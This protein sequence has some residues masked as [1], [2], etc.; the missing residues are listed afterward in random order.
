MA[1]LTKNDWLSALEKAALRAADA[2]IEYGKSIGEKHRP[3]QR[4]VFFD[5]YIGKLESEMPFEGITQKD[6]DRLDRFKSENMYK[7]LDRNFGGP[8]PKETEK[9][10][11]ASKFLPLLQGVA[12]QGEDWYSMG[13]TKL[14]GKAAELGYDPGAQE[15]FAEFLDK[16]GEYQRQHDLAQN[17]KELMYSPYFLPSMIA[18]PTAT[19][20]ILNAVATGE[21]GDKETITNLAAADALANGAMMMAPN[22]NFLKAQP[23]INAMLNAG[24]QAGI[25]GGRQAYAQNESKTGQEASMVPVEAAFAAGS[26][27]PALIKSAQM[28]ASR[29]TGPQAQAFSRGIM[30]STRAGNPAWQARTDTE[31]LVKSYNDFVKKG[32]LGANADGTSRRVLVDLG[33]GSRLK[34]INKVP[35][36]ADFWGIKPNADGTYS[37]SEIMKAY[38]KKPMQ[39]LDIGKRVTVPQNPSANVK[40]SEVL[41]TPENVGEYSRLFGAK[42]ADESSIRN[43]WSKYGMLTGRF[44]GDIGGSIEPA[45]KINPA[46]VLGPLMSGSPGDIPERMKPDHKDQNWYK[47]LKNSKNPRDVEAAKIIEEVFKQKDEEE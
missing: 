24:V 28:M 41:I 19:Q 46:D 4:E 37:A 42:F 47:K 15:G 3:D 34:E 1:E 23:V 8:S 43:A 38:D 31:N 5:M 22:L 10:I 39:V 27:R 32:V 20:E 2:R 40:A 25:E 36:M 18:Y 26:T 14:K 33:E 44:L 21:G 17:T 35:E 45:I 30:R 11:E 16:V 7:W 9:S 13:S 6:L 29:W 12:E